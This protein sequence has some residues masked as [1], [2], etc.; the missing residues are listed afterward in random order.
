MR[1]SSKR[2][3]TLGKEV[4]E[5]LGW[6]EGDDLDVLVYKGQLTILKKVKGASAGA[7]SHLKGAPGIT[8]EESLQD[9]LE[10]RQKSAKASKVA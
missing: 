10:R 9:T 4:C 8:D 1:L 2:Q 5:K 7:L 6:L 3:I